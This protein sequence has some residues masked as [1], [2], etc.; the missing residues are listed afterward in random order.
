MFP[1][2]AASAAVFLLA[3]L[4]LLER[5]IVSSFLAL[6]SDRRIIRADIFDSISAKTSFGFRDFIRIQT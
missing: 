5:K 1:V 3:L 4:D 2:G 6:A